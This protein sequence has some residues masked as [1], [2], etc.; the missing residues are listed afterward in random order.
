MAAIPDNGLQ[1]Y[2]YDGMQYDRL[3][4]QHLYCKFAAKSVGGRTLT[5]GLQYLTRTVGVPCM[6]I[7]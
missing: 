3:S 6:P 1:L 5:M 2:S 7:C 4:Q